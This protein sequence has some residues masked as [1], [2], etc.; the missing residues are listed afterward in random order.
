MI[1]LKPYFD[2]VNTTE[3][4]VQRVANEIDVLFRDGTDESKAKALEMKTHLDAAQAKHAE[5]VALYE[6]MQKANRPNNV[7]RNFVPVSPA[8]SAEAAG[9]Q[10]TV[11]KRQEYDR[12]SLIERDRFIKS[13]GKIED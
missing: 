5:A 3:A 4:E 11:I 8:A 12:M 6:S 1:D 9:S 10:P 7:A 2:A 13:G